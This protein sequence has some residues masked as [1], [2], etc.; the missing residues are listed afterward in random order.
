MNNTEFKEYLEEKRKEGLDEV[1]CWQ[2]RIAANMGLSKEKLDLLC[3][4]G[5]TFANREWMY[6]ALLDEVPI[7]WLLALEQASA[8]AVLELRRKYLMQKY[9]PNESMESRFLNLKETVTQQIKENRKVLDGLEAVEKAQRKIADLEK[10]IC[11]RKEQEERLRKELQE[12]K[13]NRLV[14]E[15]EELADASGKRAGWKHNLENLLF[16]RKIQKESAEFLELLK[17]N[18][19]SAEQKKLLLSCKEAGDSMEIIRSIAYER[20]SIETMKRIRRLLK[21]ER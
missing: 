19:L 12:L 15:D 1:G 14:A 5:L 10:E 21:S 4:K 13:E 16:K 8:N 20:F 9:G 17:G 3:K 18:N 6:L 7:E 11:E 2:V